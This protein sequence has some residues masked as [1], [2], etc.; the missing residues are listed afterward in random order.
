MMVS[1]AFFFP[2]PHSF[3]LLYVCSLISSRL[4]LVPD[5]HQSATAKYSPCLTPKTCQRPFLPK[6]HKRV[7]SGLAGFRH[8][9]LPIASDLR[10][11]VRCLFPALAANVRRC[12]T[13]G[14]PCCCTSYKVARFLA[15]VLLFLCVQPFGG[16]KIERN[17]VFPRLVP[18]GI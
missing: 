14:R 18:F 11:L 13:R 17:C 7:S 2:L 1:P 5:N 6:Q 12:S 4:F 10:R 3:F 9:A 8:C 15:K 16:E